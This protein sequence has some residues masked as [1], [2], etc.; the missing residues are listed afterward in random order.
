MTHNETQGHDK[1]QQHNST[2]LK[3]TTTTLC[4][5]K[6]LTDLCKDKQEQGWIEIQ[7]LMY[8]QQEKNRMA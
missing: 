1:T 7:D 3:H 4:N 2:T 5:I 6:Q 8:F